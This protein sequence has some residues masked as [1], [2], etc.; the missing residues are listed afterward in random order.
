MFTFLTMV[1]HYMGMINVKSRLKNQIYTAVAFVGN[2]YLL[3]IAIKFIQ[4]GGYLRGFG[5]L[6]I[7][8]VF[9]YFIVMN[10][11]FFFTE[12]K[13]PYDI[14][15][16]IEKL[17]GGRPEEVEEQEE[18][19]R[20]LSRVERNSNG[21]GANGFYSDEVL[22]PAKVRTSSSQQQNVDTLVSQMIKKGL[23]MNDF[24]G[25]NDQE[26]IQT[27]D[28]GQ[29]EFYAL[30]DGASFPY[31]DLR[32]EHG[33]A[34]IY[35]GLNQMSESPVGEVVR[36]GLSD[37]KHAKYEFHLYLANAGVSGGPQKVQGRSGLVES[38][39]KY[40]VKIQMAYKRRTTSLPDDLK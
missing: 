12:K 34:I 8:V 21:F 26:L 40:I 17:I 32:E 13:A 10:I 33:R 4:N 19:K 27:A 30:G 16:Q 6:A 39:G 25:K 20:R 11:F 31:Y 22:L 15:P 28:E 36:V 5:F 2:W 35:A 23:I 9:L 37:F 1:S 38:D 24:D 14:S 18:L 29:R 3:F 7:F